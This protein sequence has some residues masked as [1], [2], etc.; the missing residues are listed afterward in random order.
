MFLVSK[1]Q[2]K[3][4]NLQWSLMAAIMNSLDSRQFRTLYL[5]NGEDVLNNGMYACAW[6]FSSILSQ[7]RLI[8]C[9]HPT[10]ESTVNDLERSGWK[11]L[12][13]PPL[14]GAVLIWEEIQFPEDN[15]PHMHIG[16]SIGGTRAVSMNYLTGVPVEHDMTFNGTRELKRCLWHEHLR[17]RH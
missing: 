10:V 5:A 2:H 1:G 13:G 14:P 15:E 17:Q 7:F 4:L 3:S 16:F 12:Q 11:D 9:S 8:G 6:Y